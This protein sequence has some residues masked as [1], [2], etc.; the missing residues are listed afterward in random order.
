MQLNSLVKLVDENSE[1]LH[2]HD[3]AVDPDYRGLG[4]AKELLRLMVA[5]ATSLGFSSVGLVAVAGSNTYWAGHRFIE[6]E[7]K[8]VGYEEGALAMILTLR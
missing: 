7:D 3:I 8:V 1:V 6:S 2:I 5:D 4:I